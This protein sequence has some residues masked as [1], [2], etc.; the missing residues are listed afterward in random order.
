MKCIDMFA[1]CGGMSKGLQRAGYKV[2]AAFEIKPFART[3]YALNFPKVALY[4]DVRKINVNLLARQLGIAKGELDLLAACPPCQ[5]FSRMRKLNKLKSATDE[6]NK[7]IMQVLRF[8]IRLMPKAILIE[9]V[10]GLRDDP[11]LNVFSTG[12]K[13]LGYSSN[14]AVVDA[15][16]FGIPQRRRRLIFTAFKIGR[17]PS[18]FESASKSTTTVRNA[19]FGMEVP[20]TSKDPLHRMHA[21][22][23]AKVKEMIS[24]IPKNG[25][26]RSD[27]PTRF[28][29][30]CHKKPNVGFKD[31]YGRLAW[32]KVSP[33]LTRFFVN[34]SKGRYLHPRQNRALTIREGAL[35]QGFPR[36]YKFP[37]KLKMMEL[38]DLVGE[39]VPPPL[40]YWQGRHIALALSKNKS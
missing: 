21:V 2:L 6:R 38:A 24:R 30:E 36:S 26:S 9:N 4:G 33:T 20:S 5:G 32:D 25:G 12:L 22:H 14:C 19:I 1:G 37:K 23:G 8:V 15:A 18:P 11:K 29:L 7:L 34:P 3:T 17:A 10:P 35:L 13:K 28:Q 16:R 39:A 27:L 40:S 31:V